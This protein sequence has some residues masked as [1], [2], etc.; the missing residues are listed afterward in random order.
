MDRRWSILIILD[1]PHESFTDTLVEDENHLGSNLCTKEHC[2]LHAV[3]G[4]GLTW[5]STRAASIVASVVDA[6]AAATPTTGIGI[7][8]RSVGVGMLFPFGEVLWELEGFDRG[9]CLRVTGRA[10]M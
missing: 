7:G 8:T 3:A 2:F 4:A 1:T 10:E 5:S 9:R 6:S